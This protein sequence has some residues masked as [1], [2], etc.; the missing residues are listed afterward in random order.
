MGIGIGI[1]KLLEL[2]STLLVIR[3]LLTWFPNIKWENQPFSTLRQVCDVY[4]NQ[5]R[6]IIPPIGMLDISPI[7][8][9]IVLNVIIVLLARI[10]TT[11]GI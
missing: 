8:A 7:V 10:F 2:Y 11:L 1:I 9:F 6:K 5:F 3:V 4:L